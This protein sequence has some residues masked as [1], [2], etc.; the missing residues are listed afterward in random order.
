MLILLNNKLSLNCYIILHIKY[1][2]DFENYANLCFQT[3]GDR[4][5]HWTTI[6]EPKLEGMN[7][8]RKDLIVILLLSH[9][10]FSFFLSLMSLIVMFCVVHCLSRISIEDLYPLFQLTVNFLDMVYVL[11]LEYT[12]FMCD[13][14][15]FS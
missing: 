4:V 12:G 6:N 7:D 14:D 8:S 13:R 9:L 11:I 5:K 10:T 2:D 1:I 15:P 3:F